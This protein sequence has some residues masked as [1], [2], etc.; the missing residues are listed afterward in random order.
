MDAVRLAVGTL[1]VLPVG[2]PR[3]VDRSTWGRAMVLAP[4]VGAAL[5]AVA[6]A[7]GAGVSQAATP[8]LGAVAVVA[9]DAALT[10]GL[11]LDGLADVADGLGSRLPADRA[12]GIMKKSDIG[13]FGVVTLVLVLLL[14]VAAIQQVLAVSTVSAAAVLII[15]AAAASRASLTLSCR[16]GLGAAGDGLGSAVVGSV[17]TGVGWAIIAA[18]SM[19]VIVTGLAADVLV[20]ASVAVV[21]A[22]GSG[23]LWRRRCVRRFDGATGDVLGSVQQVGVTVFLLTAALVL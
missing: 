1:S 3:R 4:V 8:L 12:R 19:V 6:W 11:H 21:A 2:A 16:R 14:Q 20:P 7:L 9:V 10:R 23:E 5:G 18:V 13:P 17:P 22:L 15:G